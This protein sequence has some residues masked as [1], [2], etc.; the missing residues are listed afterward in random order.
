MLG[1][2]AAAATHVAEWMLEA[3]LGTTKASEAFA[4]M[5]ERLRAQ[6]VQIDRA[7]LAY[8]T[9]HPLNRGVGA[10]WTVQ[11]GLEVERFTY[12]RDNHASG[13]YDSPI[14]YIAVNQI[15]RLRRRLS[16]PGAT[17]DFP[18]LRDFAERGLTDY[19][20]VGQPFESF[21]ASV[22]IRIELGAE[23]MTG[24][25]ASYATE[26]EGGFS[27]EE[28]EI[29][30]WLTQPLAMVVKM[31]DQRQVA[32]N[33]A[34]CYIGREAGPRVLQ[35][36]IRRGDFASTPAVVWLS[37]LRAS[38]EMSMRL[39]REEFITTINDFFDCTAGAVE[40]AGGEPLTFIGDGALAIFP[41][42]KMGER[43]AR[44]AALAAAEQATAG[45][46]DLNL[47][48]RETDQDELRW[49]IALH[50]GVLEY[51]NIG[52]LTR[53]NWSVIGAVVNETA[54]LEGTTKEVGEPIVASR[55]FVEGLG[56]GWRSMG[57]FDLKG[58]PD[59]F[60]VFAPP[61]GSSA[62]Q[63]TAA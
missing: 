3:A 20:L 45:L 10:T 5:V 58:V 60:E 48:R 50:A 9:L 15:D 25:S 17:L 35:G 24:L 61:I 19:Y 63:E 47:K 38:T 49:G 51:G 46:T 1:R 23:T 39:P 41:I 59:L 8:T 34:N 16:G 7:Q 57:S 43:G 37:D 31:A 52:S 29:L 6:G 36:Q 28:L 21:N 32:I 26:R 44:T 30:D 13:W 56:G 54:R 40:A 4:G 53:H 42:E 55:A 14:H 27:D 2:P 33:L 22:D 11:S 62:T 12:D 18:I